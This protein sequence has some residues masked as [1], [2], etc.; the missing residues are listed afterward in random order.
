MS[1]SE[2]VA[3]P[4]P[5]VRP[6]VSPKVV[7]H[8]ISR[9]KEVYPI[10]DFFRTYLDRYGRIED[11]GIRYEDLQRFDNSI[12]LFDEA[13]RDT[14]WASVFYPPG[15]QQEI[16]DA[17]KLSYA[18]LKADGDTSITEYLNVDRVDLCLYGNTLPFRVR[19]VNRLND[20]FDYFY[21]KRVDANRV[22][23]LELEH[24]LSPNR[25]T[26]F[27]HKDTIIEE[28]II[29]IP[30]EEFV[31]DSLP[32]SRFD[33]VRMAKE[34]VKFNER[35]FV[36]LLGDMHSG[37]F[38]IDVQRDF[39]KWH[40]RMR[41][42]DFDQQS[43]HWRKQVYMPQFYPQ[44]APLI[45]MGLSCLAPPNVLQYQ[46]EERG[47]IAQRIRA[48][49][50]RFATLLDVMCEDIISSEENVNRLGEQLAYHYH[51][52]EFEQCLTMGELVKMSLNLVLSRSQ[53]TP[54][55]LPERNVS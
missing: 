51:H 7:H 22:Y 6:H 39:E 1:E 37:N 2:N 36:R 52:P 26:Y 54:S 14:L 19:I 15:E 13:G 40:Y 25:I 35:C 9:K 48:S 29:G 46:K 53:H 21:V 23:G 11:F 32:E 50:G 12:S 5:P 42:I 49:H 38:V 16:H 55:F 17:L 30:A 10:S 43:H 3:S 20:N 41:P 28:H 31:R 34:F 8:L 24:I 18:I 27:V 47:L 4:N 45:D 33:Q 44:N